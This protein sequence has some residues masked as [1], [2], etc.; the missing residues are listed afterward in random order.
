MKPRLA[1]HPRKAAGTMNNHHTHH[2][3]GSEEGFA[4]VVTL[5]TILIM[6]ILGIMLVT[7][8]AYQWKDADRT[9]PSNRALDVADSGLS[10]A[11]A[12]LA[13]DG[14][15]PY[16]PTETNVETGSKFRVTIVAD[17]GPPYYK[18]TST[19]TFTAKEDG[20]DRDY[21]RTLE[22]RIRFRGGQGYFDAFK[23]VMFSKEGNITQDTGWLGGTGTGVTING[24]LFAGARRDEDGDI[25]DGGNVVLKDEKLVAAVGVLTINGNVFAEDKVTM[26]SRSGFLAGAYDSVDGNVI[27]GNDVDIRATTAVMAGATFTVGGNIDAGGDVFLQS[28]CTAA[29]DS[30]VTVG[31]TVNAGGDVTLRGTSSFF[32]SADTVVNGDA[33]SDRDVTLYASDD[34]LAGSDARVKNTIRAVRDVNLSSY[35]GA[36]AAWPDARAGNVYA[37][38]NSSLSATSYNTWIGHIGLQTVHVDNTWQYGVTRGWTVNWPGSI[39]VDN[40]VHLNPGYGGPTVADVPDVELPQ[41]DWDW[42]KNE[43]IKQ[44]NYFAGDGDP[45]NGTP[46]TPPANQFTIGGDPSSIWVAFINDDLRLNNIIF[47][48][49]K[50]GVIVCVGDVT[51]NQ[52]LQFQTGCE[53]Q[54]IAKGDI[55]HSSWLTFNPWAN[56]TVFL[57]TN[58]EHD[59]NNDGHA[60]DVKYDMGWMRD[61]QG[62]I[63]CRGDISAPV[64][65][66]ARNCT[67]TYKAPS[68]PVEA[69]PIPFDVLS[70]REL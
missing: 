64:S 6:S 14:A 32:T 15:V 21:S 7:V 47:T 19:G 60:G 29:A 54:V 36:V 18:I 52:A 12:Y 57:Y 39:S 62:Q 4:L 11:A 59:H 9:R 38:R 63:T 68:V 53:Y 55:T 33:N 16:G 58:G 41:P 23:Y 49:N 65:G 35:C 17:P 31:G 8:A 20:L 61:L 51:V 44:G 45:F 24:S 26:R 56:D 25:I 50:K 48:P 2:I 5:F 40:E 70:F 10:W 30:A 43:A 13:K 67:I 37:N 22:Q 3:Q 27:S 1:G 69:W 66:P 34:A 42:Y 28:T 46:Y